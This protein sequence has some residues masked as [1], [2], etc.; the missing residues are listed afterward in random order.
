[1]RLDEAAEYMSIDPEVT[2]RA[3]SWSPTCSPARGRDRQLPRVGPE[4]ALSATTRR[5]DFGRFDSTDHQG[6]K[7]FGHGRVSSSLDPCLEGA[8]RR[9]LK[10]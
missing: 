7:D 2:S 1:M 3:S 6:G 4:R 9:D 5:V 8:R 10:A